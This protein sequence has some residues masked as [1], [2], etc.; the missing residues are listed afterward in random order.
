MSELRVPLDVEQLAEMAALRTLLKQARSAGAD[1]PNSNLQ[2][3]SAAGAG[4][5]AD[6][7]KLQAPST[8]QIEAMAMFIVMRLFV[9]LGYLARSTNQP[10]VLTAAGAL[11]LR[12]SLEP[13]FGEGCD[14]I[15]LLQ[16]C[17]LLALGSE[18]ELRCAV[19]AGLNEHLSG[20]YKPTHMKGN[21]M[22]QVSL[23]IQNATAAAPHQ[24][25]LLE[26]RPMRQDGTPVTPQEMDRVM[27]VI[28][29]FDRIFQ[30]TRHKTG[31]T[32]SL[33]LAALETCDRFQYDS[34]KVPDEFRQFIGWLLSNR[35]KP[36]VP[37]TTEEVLRDMAVLSKLAKP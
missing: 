25:M 32:Q 13:L 17:G 35:D 31:L 24:A 30:Y 21:L 28:G 14:P 8:K 5:I 27:V 15:E 23:H 10:G 3:P 22:R 36:R 16:G 37:K 12:E 19:F 33:I 9:V 18:Q 2:P 7:S 1:A 26:A 11:Q 6:R 4:A 34:I 29:T 20:D